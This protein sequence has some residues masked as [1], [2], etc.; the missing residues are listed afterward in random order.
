MGGCQIELSGAAHRFRLVSNH[1]R[2]PVDNGSDN[3]PVVKRDIMN[4]EII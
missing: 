2:C 3:D 1:P 4:D